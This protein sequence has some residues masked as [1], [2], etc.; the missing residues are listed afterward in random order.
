MKNV[1]DLFRNVRRFDLNDKNVQY[2]LYRISDLLS[3]EEHKEIDSYVQ[4]QLSF[5]N[6]LAKSTEFVQEFNSHI[7]NT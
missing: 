3:A 5:L 4:N 1:V 6:T 2:S 7:K